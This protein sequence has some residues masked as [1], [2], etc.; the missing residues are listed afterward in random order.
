MAKKMC[1]NETMNVDCVVLSGTA[2]GLIFRITLASTNESLMKG[3]SD[4][5]SPMLSNSMQVILASCLPVLD[6]KTT[7][8]VNVQ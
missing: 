3:L 4:V 1:T 8:G 6:G 2:G 7:N 5:S